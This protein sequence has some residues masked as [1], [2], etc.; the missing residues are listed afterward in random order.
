MVE[1]LNAKNAG[2]L[3]WWERELHDRIVPWYHGDLET[4]WGRPCPNPPG[5][6]TVRDAVMAF[7]LADWPRYQDLLE[8]PGDTDCGAILEVGCGPLVPAA[9]FRGTCYGVDPLIGCYR[10]AGYPIDEYGAVLIEEAAE[11][12][13]LPDAF[14]DTVMCQNSIDHVDDFEA[15]CREIQRVAKPGALI[16]ID[17]TY[18][19]KPTSTEPQVI[20]DARMVAAF[21]RIPLEKLRV[22]ERPDVQCVLWGTV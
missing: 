13:S 1:A 17:V 8:I 10:E 7:R 18:R 14:F 2:E 16:R 6:G 3:G 11:E 9:M 19:A 20:D 15:V 5:T 21:G 22:H 12:T 4:L